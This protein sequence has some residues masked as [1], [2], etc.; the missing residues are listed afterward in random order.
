MCC[1]P[2]GY[3][4]RHDLATEQHSTAAAKS[5]QLC[6]TLCNPI[7]GSP[8]GSAIPGILQ[9]RTLEW[10]TISFSNAWKWKVK[11]KSLSRVWL[12]A[13]PWTAAY[14]A[15][16]SMGF[17]RQ[18]YWSGVPLPSWNIGTGGLEMDISFGGTQ[19]NPSSRGWH[20][21]SAFEFR[22]TVPAFL[23]QEMGLE[24]HKHG[25]RGQLR[26]CCALSPCPSVVALWWAGG[27]GVPGAG[28]VSRESCLW[29]GGGGGRGASFTKLGDFFL[30]SKR[31]TQKIRETRVYGRAWPS[32]RKMLKHSAYAGGIDARRGLFQKLPSLSVCWLWAKMQV[33]PSQTVLKNKL[34]WTGLRILWQEDI[35]HLEILLLFLEPNLARTA[36]SL[37]TGWCW[38]VQANDYMH[39]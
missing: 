12:F 29:F 17:S 18:E 39:N 22:T 16:L 31:R 37:I 20:D 5:L 1:S 24:G 4:V 21:Q 33:S 34:F 9:A 11:V 28:A 36:L 30:L 7:H 35:G 6:P 26:G 2:W 19:F 14:Q 23:G 13:T 8:P 38:V 3:R 15:P 27:G 10:V 25:T 32:T